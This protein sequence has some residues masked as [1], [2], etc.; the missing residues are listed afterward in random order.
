VLNGPEWK[1]LGKNPEE[2]TTEETAQEVPKTILQLRKLERAVS[3]ADFEAL[4]LEPDARAARARCLPRH[5][6]VLDPER[7]RA[8][9]VSVVILPKS[10]AEP[11][12][13]AIIEAVEKHLELRL[14]L[15]TRLHVVGPRY[16]QV[17]VNPTIVPMPDVLLPEQITSPDQ[18][19]VRK[20]VVA[21]V[22]NFL[23]PLP[24]LE[25]GTDGWPFGR[26]VFV[27]D[28]FA[29]LDRLQ[30]VDYVTAVN[31]TS[32][33]PDRLIKNEAGEL[34]GAEVKP[35][36][37]VEAQITAADVTVQMP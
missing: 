25:K 14:L 23:D 3:C 31:L 12:L 7:E 8:G 26:N 27:S 30:N 13:P 24:S 28:L 21:A 15:T 2:L 11:E 37:L 6:M 18:Q 20:D 5:N 33:P 32:N 17:N 16:V 9:H 1:P 29:L 22:E 4:A 36:E 10:G 34:I 35:Y 19:D